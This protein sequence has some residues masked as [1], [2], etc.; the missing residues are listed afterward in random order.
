MFLKVGI[1]RSSPKDI[2]VDTRQPGDRSYFS[3]TYREVRSRRFD[4]RNDVPLFEHG[5]KIFFEEH[6]VPIGG[7]KRY[8]YSPEAA[9][10]RV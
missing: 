4:E 5:V 10:T 6:F 9:C 7:L 8:T 1:V 2:R 3:M